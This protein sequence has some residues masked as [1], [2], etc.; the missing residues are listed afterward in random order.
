[1]LRRI[2]SGKNARMLRLIGLVVSIGLADSLNPTTIAP[3][4]FL[5]LGEH[6]RAR[7]LRF[8]FGVFLVYLLGGLIVA[9]GPGE[10]LLSLIPRPDRRTRWIL[11]TIAGVA[12]LVAAAYVWRNRERLSQRELPE[13][14][15]AGK[16][17]ALL[18]ATITAVELPTAFPYF[19]AIA[20]IVGSGFGPVRQIVLLVIFNLCFIVPLL[21]IVVTLTLAGDDAKRVL[22]SIR[23]WLQTHWPKLLVAVGLIAGVF[24]TV[25]G[26]TGLASGGHG[27]AG[28]IARRF[29]RLLRP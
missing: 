27:H 6:A 25:L 23:N 17:S 11:E 8:T 1:L 9:L 29:R 18:G 19:A 2:G 5:S 22:G 24:V 21:A 26:V 7:V 28:R 10:I 16:S 20:A 4:L 14:N 12:M 15:V 3:A 13:A